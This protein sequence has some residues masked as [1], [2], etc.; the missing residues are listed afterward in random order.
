MFNS[1]I[2]GKRSKDTTGIVSVRDNFNQQNYPVPTITSFSVTDE[3]YN[4][5]DDTAIDTAGGQTIVLN[6]YGFAPGITVMV[7]SSNISVVTY[8]DPNRISFTAPALSSG[9]YTVYATNVNG[10]TAILVPGLVYSGIP[11]FT[12][13][14]GSLGSYY[15][16]TSINTSVSATGD[17][18]ITYSVVSGSLPSG[19][20]LSSNGTLS[21][22]AP[23]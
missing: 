4:P 2:L 12:T 20:T 17:T 11:T 13:S 1:G 8:I 16:T 7:N 18:P 22:T 5:T 10:G 21:G 19:A 3:S 14:A 23:A 9:S 6:G 15:E